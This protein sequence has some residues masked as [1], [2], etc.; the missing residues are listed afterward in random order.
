M[1]EC[2]SAASGRKANGQ[3]ND[4]QKSHGA[5]ACLEAI[6]RVTRSSNAHRGR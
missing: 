1:I 4:S 2:V 3:P 5:A 6:Q